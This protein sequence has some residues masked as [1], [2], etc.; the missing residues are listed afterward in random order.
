MYDQEQAEAQAAADVQFAAE[1]A[2]AE[3]PAYDVYAPAPAAPATRALVPST[4][5][6]TGAA[7]W[8]EMEVKAL[9]LSLLMAHFALFRVL[10]R[11]YS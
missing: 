5:V 8:D 11:K 6:P 9:L 7:A 1:M 4:E 3:A 10:G 2:A